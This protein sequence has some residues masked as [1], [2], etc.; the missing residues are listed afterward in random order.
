MGEYIDIAKGRVKQA[1][2]DLSDNQSL[3]D[4][5]TTDILKGKVKGAFKDIKQAARDVKHAVK[6]AGRK[7]T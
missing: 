4:E 6:S 1:A 7:L 3:K 5:G 2:G